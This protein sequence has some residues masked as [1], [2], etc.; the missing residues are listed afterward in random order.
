MIK[1]LLL[2]LSSPLC[3]AA[4][5]PPNIIY[6]LA[7]DLGYGDLSING[8]QKF[9]TP[10]IDSIGKQGMVFT[11]H[12][13]GNTVCSASRA[14]LMT[15]LGSGK[16]Y[17]RG[18]MKNESDAAIPKE[19]ITLPEVLKEAGYVTGAFGKWGLGVTNSENKEELP[20]MHGFDEFC[21][22]KSQ[23]IAHTYYPSSYVHNGQEVPLDGKTYADS[24]FWEAARTFIKANAATE[25][26]FFCYIPT[27]VPHAAMHAPE[28]LHTKWRS[29]F[30]EYDKVIGKYS[31]GP[32]EKT[33]DVT[34]PIAGFAAMMEHLDIQVGKV[35]AE[36]KE[37]GIEENTLIIFASDNGTHNEGGHDPEF[38]NSSAGLKGM[39]RSLYE[40]GIRTPM[41][42]LW[43]GTI[44]PG[45]KA[46]ILSG[47][48]D[49][50]PTLAE[51]AD[52]RAPYKVNGISFL[53]TLTGKGYQ[54]KHAYLYFEYYK[55]EKPFAQAL[56]SDTL[57]VI[58]EKGQLHELYD[59][60][61]DPYEENNLAGSPNY[62]DI[63]KSAKEIM[64]KESKPM[65]RSH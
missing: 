3:L 63:L 35:L 13:S 43:T 38:F 11:N 56:R 9:K 65:N 4:P 1:F 12:Y 17:V 59:L 44:T 32:G 8:Q 49:V 60:E 62:I 52:R 55:D 26:P 37:L 50:F 54:K 29:K 53:P 10:N 57:K 2:L 42:A 27:A 14:V 22:W 21:G 58:R 28:A 20:S 61:V 41:M 51:A 18:N 5:K 15:G 24:I 7:D 25:T 19:F 48:Q 47:F 16:C 34:N 39:K 64:V 31:A 33:P 23:R 36:V 30:R 6:I 46:H 40:G 45:S